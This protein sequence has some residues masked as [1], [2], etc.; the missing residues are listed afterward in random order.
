[1]ASND[2]DIYNNFEDLDDVE[3]SDEEID[4]EKKEIIV[5]EDVLEDADTLNINI[6]DTPLEIMFQDESNMVVV[7]E[8]ESTGQIKGKSKDS[9]PKI[10]CAICQKE[11]V[12]LKY[13]E[14]HEKACGKFQC[15]IT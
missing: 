13:K 7:V 2:D 5:E 4:F 11:Y 3:V 15:R 12:I 8:E 14:E 1:M 9:K 10:Y 6:E